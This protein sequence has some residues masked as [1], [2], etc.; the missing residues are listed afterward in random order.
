MPQPVLTADRALALGTDAAAPATPRLLAVPSTVT[1]AW[2]LE[3]QAADGTRHAV[4]IDDATGQTTPEPAQRRGDAIG[5]WMRRVHQGR[6][7][8]PVWAA[9]AGLCGALPT[10][11]AITGVLMWLR[12]RRNMAALRRD[13][14]AFSDRRLISA[15]NA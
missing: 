6:A 1:K 5:A 15:E 13:A 12:K 2:R 7:H 4:S 8:G 10:L 14:A 11:L 9:L 3:V